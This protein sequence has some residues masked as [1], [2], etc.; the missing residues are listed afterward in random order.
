MPAVHHC[1]LSYMY[2]ED[3][4]TPCVVPDHELFVL[5]HHATAGY[6][7]DKPANSMWVT[8]CVNT[9]FNATAGLGN[10]RVRICETGI[11]AASL[12]KLRKSGR[13]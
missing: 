7:G 11:V 13:T 5:L 9:T 6:P 10:N 8:S 2:S 1:N 12:P 4:S 3:I